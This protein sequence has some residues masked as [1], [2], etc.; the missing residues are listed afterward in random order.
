M[1]TASRVPKG[2]NIET[3]G[4]RVAFGWLEV[5]SSGGDID[6][7]LIAPSSK[8]KKLNAVGNAF[9]P[10]MIMEYD[11]VTV[12]LLFACM[13]LTTIPADLDLTNDSPLKDLDQ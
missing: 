5:H 6:S 8:V 3:E 1:V 11:G 9:V 13:Y 10:L 12:D 7:V 4:K 2:S